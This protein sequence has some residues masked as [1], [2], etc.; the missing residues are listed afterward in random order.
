MESLLI[1]AAPC[2]S[3]LLSTAIILRLNILLRHKRSFPHTAH[4][5]WWVRN[6]HHIISMCFEI[7]CRWRKTENDD[8]IYC[9]W[10]MG[11]RKE[12]K[13]TVAAFSS[14]D[15][16]AVLKRYTN[17]L[18]CV[19]I[20]V[21]FVWYVYAYARHSEHAGMQAWGCLCLN[22][23]LELYTLISVPKTSLIWEIFGSCCRCLRNVNAHG[24]VCGLFNA[25]Q[26]VLTCSHQ[27][28]NIY[29]CKWNRKISANE[30]LLIIVGLS[31]F[32]SKHTVPECIL[33]IVRMENG[34]F[35]ILPPVDKS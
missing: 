29:R 8:Q 9:K 27:T 33:D 17:R 10:W 22:W 25:S 35:R 15:N 28:L 24:C 1:N 3:V 7:L 19:W 23:T 21:C 20:F 13:S 30:A 5:L 18:C 31:V 11:W 2:L 34:E 32:H 4:I 12:G 14:N 16:N 6:V 26:S